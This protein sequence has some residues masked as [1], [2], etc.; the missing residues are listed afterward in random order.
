[1]YNKRVVAFKIYNQHFDKKMS[2]NRKSKG[3]EQGIRK[4]RNNSTI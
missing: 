3:Y 4:R 1:M 2:A